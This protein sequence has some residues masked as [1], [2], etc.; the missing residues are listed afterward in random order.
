[1]V[2]LLGR[3]GNNKQALML[4]IERLGDV[5]GVGCHVSSMGKIRTDSLGQ[6]IDFA[7]E[8]ND[9]DLWEDLLTYSE[10]KPS[11]RDHEVCNQMLTLHASQPS[12]AVFW[13]ML[14]WKSILSDLYAASRMDSR[15]LVSS[16]PS[17]RF[18]RI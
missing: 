8:Q 17:S 14:A 12:F 1:M 11:E 10:T 2:Y 18:S 15:Y 9:H 7:K 6:A 5:K 13:K 4:I 16:L 3:M